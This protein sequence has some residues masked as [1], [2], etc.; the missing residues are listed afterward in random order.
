MLTLDVVADAF[1]LLAHR[2]LMGLQVHPVKMVSQG[3]LVRKGKQALMDWMYSWSLKR[4]SH[5]SFVHQVLLEQLALKGNVVDPGN[6][7][8]GYVFSFSL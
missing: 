1:S 4:D 7:A 2:G 8:I 6:R 3:C 5:A